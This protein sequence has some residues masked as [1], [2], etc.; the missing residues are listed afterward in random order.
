MNSI[1]FQSKTFLCSRTVDN[2]GRRIPALFGEQKYPLLSVET[3]NDL[4]STL[5]PRLISFQSLRSS[6]LELQLWQRKMYNFRNS[7]FETLDIQFKNM[8]A[9]CPIQWKFE[10]ALRF[11]R[12]EKPMRCHF[13]YIEH[14]AIRFWKS[15]MSLLERVVRKVLAMLY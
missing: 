9:S 8:Q 11:K 14:R 10:P 4:Q 12:L 6:Y 3:A 1:I 5:K 7:E 15:S 2:L 13:A